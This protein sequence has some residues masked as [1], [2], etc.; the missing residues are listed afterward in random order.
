MIVTFTNILLILSLTTFLCYLLWF[1]V[2]NFERIRDVNSEKKDT[3]YDLYIMV[4]LLNEEN[5]IFSYVNNLINELNH[6]DRSINPNIILIDDASSDKTL[7]NL[8]TL[9][10]ASLGI[11]TNIHVLSRRLPNA[12]QGKGAALNFGLNYIAGLDRRQDDQHT[13]IGI[14]DADG[15]MSAKA[16]TSVIG[17][18]ENNHVSMVQTAVGMNRRNFNWLS[19]MQDIEFLGANSFMQ[20]SRNRLGQAI[21]S[22][23]GQFLTLKMAQDVRWGDSLLEDFE[24][25][26]RGLLKQHRA[27]FL[28]TAIVYQEAVT[29]LRPLL[30]QRIRW[31]EGSMQCFVKYLKKIIVSP[32]INMGVKIDLSLFLILPFFSM[33]LNFANIASILI[34]LTNVFTKRSLP[35]I[36]VFSIVIVFTLL[37]WLMTAIEYFHNT[38]NLSL[39]T[40]LLRA[41]QC[42]FYNI[43]LSFIPY[44]ACFYLVTGKRAW[45]KTTHGQNLALPN[46]NK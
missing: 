25:T 35:V 18:F 20:E 11:R 5:T 28:P 26:V 10:E 3:P 44:V 34:Q 42:I 12:Q 17:A 21:A 37:I 45:A 38:T 13:I 9:C 33:L 6:V 7:K 15:F 36:I 27:L 1:T 29:S 19:K 16:M 4:P 43:I 31:C 23:N 41:W 30:I 14:I 24:F 2:F 40:C 46:G 22:G 32:H 39:L 8:H